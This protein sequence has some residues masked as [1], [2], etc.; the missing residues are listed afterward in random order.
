MS[1]TN[2]TSTAAN[3]RLQPV[4]TKKVRNRKCDLLL[5]TFYNIT[6]FVFSVI[7]DLR[8]ICWLLVYSNTC[9][10]LLHWAMSSGALTL[11]PQGTEFLKY[12]TL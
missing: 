3:L 8:V 12:V 9:L 11:L 2:N 4:S 6:L 7:L 10:G 5:C 1:T